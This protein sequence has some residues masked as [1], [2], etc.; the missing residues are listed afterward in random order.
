MAT[1][2]IEA[3]DHKL[4]VAGERIETGEWSEVNSPYDGTPIGR[5][6][7]ADAA[8]V[9]RAAKAAHEAV[10]STKFPQHERAAVLDR[11]AH[12]VRERESELAATISAEAVSYTHLTLPTNREV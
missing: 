1:E 3:T 8:T 11:A 10:T 7:K 2:T 9:D 6:P 12:I 5:V 4:I